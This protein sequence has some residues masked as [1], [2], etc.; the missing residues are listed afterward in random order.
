MGSEIGV[1][2]EDPEEG[3]EEVEVVTTCERQINVNYQFELNGIEVIR[4]RNGVFYPPDSDNTKSETRGGD[5]LTEHYRRS[6]Y[7][8]S[9]DLYVFQ[10]KYA[11]FDDFPG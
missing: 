3:P 5:D 7:L 6:R 2:T 1:K 11:I 9:D 8:K 10:Y 4:W